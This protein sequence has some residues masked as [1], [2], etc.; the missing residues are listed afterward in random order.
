[1]S[2]PPPLW[3]Y[4]HLTNKICNISNIYLIKKSRLTRAEQHYRLQVSILV[5]VS[6]QLCHAVTELL[7][8]PN[9]LHHLL[10]PLPWKLVWETR[11][12][13]VWYMKINN[14][15]LFKPLWETIKKNMSSQVAI[16]HH[17]WQNLS[18]FFSFFHVWAFI[19]PASWYCR[20]EIHTFSSLHQNPICDIWA[21]IY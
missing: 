8:L 17:C 5:A 21:I 7:E 4:F 20:W 6:L 14:F 3:N 1:M 11:K 10:H 13:P 18:C 9:M 19:K 2:P 12:C 15:M 16:P